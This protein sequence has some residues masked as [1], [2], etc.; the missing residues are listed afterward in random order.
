MQIK[1]ILTSIGKKPT[2][3]QLAQDE[4]YDAQVKLMQAQN[5]LEWAQANVDYQTNRVARLKKQIS[6]EAL[7]NTSKPDAKTNTKSS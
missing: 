6:V 3:E 5:A 7:L 4:L 1:N 2:I